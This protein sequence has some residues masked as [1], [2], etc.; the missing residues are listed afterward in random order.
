MAYTKCPFHFHL[1]PCT[2]SGTSCVHG[3]WCRMVP[4]RETP[5]LTSPS[6]H[7][8]DL[9]DELSTVRGCLQ[10]LH[11]QS[12]LP[13]TFLKLLDSCLC[14]YNCINQWLKLSTYFRLEMGCIARSYLLSCC[15]DFCI[16]SLF[17]F[18]THSPR[19][20]IM[21][22]ELILNMLLRSFKVPYIMDIIYS[23]TH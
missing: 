23:I 17:K 9:P 19:Q 16:N 13:K 15:C 12:H 21:V 1:H 3:D 7:L 22:R 20:L 10:C 18:L 8:W 14:P 2:A 4:S 5:S 11:H 6:L